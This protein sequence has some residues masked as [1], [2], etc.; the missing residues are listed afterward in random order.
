VV[1]LSN[2]LDNETWTGS[3]GKDIKMEE[4]PEELKDEETPSPEE[5]ISVEGE[6]SAK[7]AE[8]LTVFKDGFAF[9][10]TAENNV[11]MTDSSAF[12]IAAGGNAQISDSGVFSIAAG[13]DLTFHDGGALSIQVGGNASVSEG[14]ALVLVCREARVDSGTVGVLLSPKATLGEGVK[15]QMG[16]KEALAFGAAF[17]A[18]MAVLG[19]LLS[20]VSGR[21][22][23]GSKKGCC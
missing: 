13:G 12:G 23:P 19:W 10:I 14:G 16:M 2:I 9:G 20:L 4:Q 3:I 17:G 18:A 22:K 21:G 15:V 7:T 1:N 5:E 11:T 8:E 6:Q